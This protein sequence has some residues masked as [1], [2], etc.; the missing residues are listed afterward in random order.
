MTYQH[1][2]IN[3]KLELDDK[4]AKL[5]AF[6]DT[7]TYMNLPQAERARLLRQSQLMCEYSMVL[8]ERIDAFQSGES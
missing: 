6:F 1:R 5:I 3:E 7:D 2:V 8:G 4:I